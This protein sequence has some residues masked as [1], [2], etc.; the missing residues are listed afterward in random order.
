MNLQPNF[1]CTGRFPQRSRRF[2][3]EE[4]GLPGRLVLDIAFVRKGRLLAGSAL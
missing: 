1:Y 2:Y 4:Q 3:T